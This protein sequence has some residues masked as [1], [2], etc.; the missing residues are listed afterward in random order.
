MTIEWYCECSCDP[1]DLP[2]V[3][4]IANNID[5]IPGALETVW[6]PIDPTSCP[7]QSYIQRIASLSSSSNSSTSSPIPSSLY[8]RTILLIG[9][10]IDRANAQYTCHLLSGNYSITHPGDVYWAQDDITSDP[11]SEGWK[12]NSYSD[13][14]FPTICHVESI[15]LVIMNVFHFG[16]DQEEYF[17]WKDQYGP[18]YTTEERIDQIARNLVERVGR[19]IDILEFSSGVSGPLLCNLSQFRGR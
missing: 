14:S 5:S 1:H 12:P 18:P 17:T 6:Q 2:G 3:L 15:D 11:N 16:L 10:S 4:H 19:K 13:R 7:A 8:N 9:D